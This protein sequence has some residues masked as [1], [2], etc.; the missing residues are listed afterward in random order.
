MQRCFPQHAHQSLYCHYHDTEWG[1][2]VFDERLLFEMLCLEGMQAGLSFEIVLKKREAFKKAFFDFHPE[3]VAHMTLEDVDAI[4]QM[5][6]IIRNRRK[7]CSIINNAKVFL[8]IQKNQGSFAHYLW[9]FTKHKT[10]VNH[11]KTLKEVPCFS[12]LSILVAK[13]LKKRGMSFVGKKIMYSYLQAVGVINDHLIG[14]P[15]RE[16]SSSQQEL[17]KAP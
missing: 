1:V 6:G 16:K 15:F 17:F 5:P 2:P 13:D 4:L 10:L 8:E 3:K 11:W 9:G 12:D 7:L 14:C